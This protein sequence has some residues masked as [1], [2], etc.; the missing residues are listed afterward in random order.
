M[1][2]WHRFGAVLLLALLISACGS[3]D[4]K[5][6]TAAS[7]RA[8]G[9]AVAT[10]GA[11]T[12]SPA[13]A[14]PQV[15]GKLVIY[16]ALDQ[17]TIDLLVAA[18]KKKYPDVD[19]QV[20]GIAAAG[21]VATRIRAEKD[22]PKADIFLGGSTEFHEPLANDGLLVSYKSPV[23]SQIEAKYSDTEGRFY[24]W[25]LGVLGIVIN[26][27]RFK[28]AK[29]AEP[30]TWDDLLDPA[31]KGK[32]VLPNPPTT[33]GG[34]IFLAD[35]I[36][37]FA[38][39]EAKALDFMKKLDANVAQYTQRSPDAINVVAQGEFVAAVNWV[40]DILAQK[41]RGFP[42]KI[43]IPPDTA[44]EIGGVSIVKGSNPDA[45]KAFVDFVLG[46]EAGKINSDSS[47]RI[48]VRG[49]VAPPEGAVKI[50]DVKLVNY[51]RDWATKEKDRLLK[52]WQQATGK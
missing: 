26:T 52:A 41:K 40:H 17:A 2:T 19:P 7:P 8:T 14:Q 37:R 38:R 28:D 31:W 20:V 32:L 29:V 4:E 5:G 10:T 27:D 36:F 6:K 34:Y 18:F 44:F 47:N 24:G 12:G 45:A 35:Q 1:R 49:D 23:A 43:I 51:D 46:A 39:D 50:S 33:G 3:S 48:S 9:A 22:S 30:K 42:L 16:N 25:Y 13:A 21:E 15:K 11:G